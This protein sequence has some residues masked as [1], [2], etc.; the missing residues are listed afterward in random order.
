MA[1]KK[2]SFKLMEA[3]EQVLKAE[4]EARAIRDQ[5][6]I[7]A[8]QILEDARAE[9]KRLIASAETEAQAENQKAKA[10]F[11]RSAEQTHTEALG[12]GELKSMAL[13]HG[14][15]EKIRKAA[16]QLLRELVSQ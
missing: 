10:A 8:D 15:E 3:L 11:D 12:E 7:K 14:A 1:W 2:E 16:E 13:Q 4:E 9:G 5:A 6:R